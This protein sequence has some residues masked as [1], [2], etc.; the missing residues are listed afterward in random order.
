[1]DNNTTSKPFISSDF[2]QAPM[3]RPMYEL[4]PNQNAPPTSI[5]PNYNTPPPGYAYN[6]NVNTPGYAYPVNYQPPPNYQVNVN[7]YQQYPP[8]TIVQ[9]QNITRP[10]ISGCGRKLCLVFAILLIVYLIIEITL[11]ITVIKIF[12]V[13]IVIDEIGILICI[14]LFIK[15]FNGGNSSRVSAIIFTAVVWFVGFGLR[16]VA[17]MMYNGYDGR[18]IVP[19]LPLMLVRTFILFFSIAAVASSQINTR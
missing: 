10:N 2:Q 11:F 6:P 16:G 14:I 5:P 3:E 15:I 13:P 9:V 1:M 17:M 19:L 8:Q 12:A 18:M 4:N 7:G